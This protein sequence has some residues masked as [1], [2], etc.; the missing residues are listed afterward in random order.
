M[1]TI[2]TTTAVRLVE[3]RRAQARAV[4]QAA[5][6][7]VKTS[8]DIYIKEKSGNRQIRI[9]WL[10]EEIEYR[11]GGTTVA[12][13]DIMNR[14]EVVVPTG[15]GLAVIS[16]TSEFPGLRRTD[17]GLLRGTYQP[18]EYYHKILEDWRAKGTILTVLVTGYPINKDVILTDYSAT[19]TGGFGDMEY[20]VE[21]TEYRELTVTKKTAQKTANTTT[22][23]RPAKKT[24]AY[25]IKKGDTLWAIAKKFLGSGNKWKTIY[26][27]NKSI[28][29]STAKKHGKK[30]S[31]NGHWIYPGCKISIPQ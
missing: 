5:V 23:K 31:S 8:V 21:F 28:I 11:S 10:P 12:T 6:K 22:T 26:N 1:P 2:T 9:P 13:Y 25:T 30:S 20:E 15:T 7:K 3:A 17:M 27:A 29:E 16:W 19:P 18:P 14:G 24:T 4:V